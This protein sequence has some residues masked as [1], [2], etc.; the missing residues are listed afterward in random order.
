M[1]G[2]LNILQNYTLEKYR[3]NLSTHQI[4]Q[5]N[6]DDILAASNFDT[7]LTVNVFAHGWVGFSDQ[8]YQSAAS[9]NIVNSNPIFQV[10][11]MQRNFTELLDWLQVED[12]NAISIDWPVFQRPATNMMRKVP[13]FKNLQ[14]IS[15]RFSGGRLNYGYIQDR[16]FF[17]IQSL[18]LSFPLYH[19]FH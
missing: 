4:L 13:V 10:L 3:Q 15:V 18:L 16:G 19:F 6:N 8:G 11:E 9:I 5:L 7:N 12:C 14:S 2:Q 1:N 17:P